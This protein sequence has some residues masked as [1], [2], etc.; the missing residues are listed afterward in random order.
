MLGLDPR[1]FEGRKFKRAHGCRACENSGYRGRIAL[2]EHMEMDQSLRELCFRG[3][4][5]E[6]L[7][8]NAL[9]SGALVGLITDGARK[10]VRGQTS[11]QEVMRVTRLLSE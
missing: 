3:A 10:I 11:I 6:E 8:R 4:S 5:L 7:R 9:G 1:S 2:F